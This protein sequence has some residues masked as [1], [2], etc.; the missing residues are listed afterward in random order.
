MRNLFALIFSF[1]SI[2][3]F[4]QNLKNEIPSY[5][6]TNYSYSEK[7]LIAFKKF[8]DSQIRIAIKKKLVHYQ[9][10]KETYTGNSL[11]RFDE[12]NQTNSIEKVISYHFNLPSPNSRYSFNLF[13]LEFK[14]DAI[15]INTLNKIATIAYS[16]EFGLTK[17]PNA[18]FRIHNY[19][20]WLFTPNSLSGRTFKALSNKLK[21]QFP[22][23]DIDP[24]EN[25]I[26]Y[27]NTSKI[28]NE[29]LL[30]KWKIKFISPL[31]ENDT[32][33][34]KSYDSITIEINKE[35]IRIDNTESN[36]KT[37][38][39]TKLPDAETFLVNYRQILPEKKINSNLKKITG[40][41]A[42]YQFVFE[43]SNY[44]PNKELLNNGV[45]TFS[46]TGFG[47]IIN[48]AYYELVKEQ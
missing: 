11:K 43:H 45:I 18:V 28:E 13:T 47:L 23:Q 34:K 25:H 37:I 40:E 21:S 7:K 8:S 36:I 2:C 32:E 6:S 29:K 33:Q 20:I 19:I 41:I 39:L 17:S 26:Q 42:Y 22:A 24:L 35:T 16:A 5:K 46:N 12:I 15:A 3:L 10:K 30:G 14:N 44:F 27:E 4:S 1:F 9:V 38:Y 31:Y 48:E